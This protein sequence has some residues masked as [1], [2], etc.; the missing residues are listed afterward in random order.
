M[1]Y[2]ANTSFSANLPTLQIAW[3]STSLG[4]FKE[5]PRK[6]YYNLILGWVPASTS[7][8]L[9]FGQIYHSA[10]EAYDHAKAKGDNHAISMRAAVR[11]AMIALQAF[12]PL[13]IEWLPE[14]NPLTLVR[15]VVW[16]LDQFEH[17]TLETIILD[18]GKPAIELSFRMETD[19]KAPSGE[20]Y[21]LCGHK[22]KMA[23]HDGAVYIVDRKT[24]KSALTAEFFAKF[25]PDNQFSLYTLAGQVIYRERPAGIIVDAAQ[26]GVT[27]SRY[28]RGMVPRPQGVVDEWYQDLGHYLDLAARYAELNYWPQNDKSCNAYGGCPYRSVCSKSPGLRNRFLETSFVKR[29]WDPMVSRGVE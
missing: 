25:A 10:L 8:H 3:D 18:N 1:T 26:V 9:A 16:Y 2:P 11:H 29:I 20:T 6:Y 27:F 21:V 24:T 19:Y 23:R 15:T 5:C 12:P 17:D 14:K 7:A 28:L 13:S 22:D 4:A